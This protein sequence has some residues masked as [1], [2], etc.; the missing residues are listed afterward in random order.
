V[1][2]RVSLPVLH[3]GKLVARAQEMVRQRKPRQRGKAEIQ[4]EVRD[5][6][7]ELGSA[8]GDVREADER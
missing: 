1:K 2:L 5:D 6:R 7:G 4:D 3:T 8:A